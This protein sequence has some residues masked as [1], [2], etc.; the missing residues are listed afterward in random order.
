MMYCCVDKK[1][2]FLLNVLEIIINFKSIYTKKFTK[3][4]FYLNIFSSS[5]MFLKIFFIFCY[6]TVKYTT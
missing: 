2:C 3:L 5:Y 6:T 4:N 1:I